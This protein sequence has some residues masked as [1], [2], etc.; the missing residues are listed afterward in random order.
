MKK[1]L[2]P[3]CLILILFIVFPGNSLAQVEGGEFKI[4][5]REDIVTEHVKWA[6]PYIQGK[7]KVLFVPSITA[8]RSVIELAQLW[9][10]VKSS[11]SEQI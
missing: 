1:K 4:S 3:S 2:I 7:T 8:G 10:P 5:F 6:K 9:L 11:G